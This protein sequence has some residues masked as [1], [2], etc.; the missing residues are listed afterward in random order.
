M[1]GPQCSFFS[2][3]NSQ[4]PQSPFPLRIVFLVTKPS[5]LL[6]LLSSRA[7]R[8]QNRVGCS[9]F[10][11]V[12]FLKNKVG[13]KYPTHLKICVQMWLPPLAVRASLPPKIQAST[14]KDRQLLFRL[15]KLLLTHWPLKMSVGDG[16]GS[17]LGDGSFTSLHQLIAE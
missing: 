3:F 9:T 10:K 1:V 4:Q 6:Y 8:S 16:R 11:V 17:R 5:V 15:S 7:E 12:R 2:V 13:R 14:P